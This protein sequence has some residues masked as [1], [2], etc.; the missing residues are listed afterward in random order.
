[1]L[2]IKGITAGTVHLFPITSSG[3]LLV[4]AMLLETALGTDV[5]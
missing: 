3:E 4:H 1:L 5:E 2:I